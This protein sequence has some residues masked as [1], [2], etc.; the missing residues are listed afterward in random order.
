MIETIHSY[1][2]INE[3]SYA[4]ELFE[5]L[6]SVVILDEHG[7]QSTAVTEDVLDKNRVIWV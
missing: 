2:T 5:R 4:I 1:E 6:V 7:R 3:A